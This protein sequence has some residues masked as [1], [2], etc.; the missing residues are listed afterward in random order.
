MGI[1][2]SLFLIAVGAILTFAVNVTTSGSGIDLN[3]V[4]VIL[5]IVGGIGLLLSLL[6]WSSF[7]PWGPGRRREETVVRDR[8]VL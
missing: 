2:V 7:A 6:F 3:T 8:E 1:G 4:G 5:M